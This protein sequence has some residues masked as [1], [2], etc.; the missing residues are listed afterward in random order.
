M[1]ALK[2]FSLVSAQRL[3]SG[4]GEMSTFTNLVLPAFTE[5]DSLPIEFQ[6]LSQVGGEVAEI[7]P[8]AGYTL[9]IGIFTSAGVQLAYQSTWTADALNDV[10]TGVL[11]L[12][13]AALTSALSGK[14]VGE[15]INA[16][17]SIQYIDTLGRVATALPASSAQAAIKIAKAAITVGAV[18]VPPG[19]VAATLAYVSNACVLNDP[20]Q[21]RPQIVYSPDGTRFLF[22]PDNDGNP[23]FEPI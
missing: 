18:T 1:N 17:F 22:Y 7:L 13:D 14:V 9:K 21:H 2:L 23:H 8:V 20:G 16:F 12:N 5:G 6:A 3:V 15:T 4:R 19:E 10:F 11:N